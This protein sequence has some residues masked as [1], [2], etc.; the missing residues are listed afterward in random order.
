MPYTLTD[1]VESILTVLRETGW[2][3]LAEEIV[4][5]IRQGTIVRR[6]ELGRDDRDDRD[7]RDEQGW[8]HVSFSPNGQLLV[9]ISLIRKRTV[10]AFRQTKSAL[11]R[12][13]RFV[14]P[15]CSISIEGQESAIRISVDPETELVVNALDSILDQ[16]ALSEMDLYDTEDD[17][18]TGEEN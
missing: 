18:S 16:I 10:F 2:I 13:Q 5:R 8:T 17:P 12:Y 6:T 11:E 1:E 7:D 9:A 4:A 15:E 14:D 3:S